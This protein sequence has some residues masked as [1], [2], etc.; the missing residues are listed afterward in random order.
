MTLRKEAPRKKARW[1]ALGIAVTA[2]LLLLASVA[3][4]GA[5][6]N[7]SF[8]GADGNL[9]RDLGTPTTSTD[10]NSFSPTWGGTAPYQNA[11]TTANGWAFKGLTDA[12]ASTTDTGFAGGTKQDDNCATVKGGKAPNK[13]DLKRVYLATKTVTVSSASHVFLALA[14]ERIPQNTVNASAHVGFEFNQGSTPC[15]T[16]HD[17]L[18]Q[19][20]A[21]DLLIVYDFEG[22]SSGS[23]TL[24]LRKWVT[25]GAC[26]ISSDSAPCWGPAATLTT[27][28]G[29]TAEAKVDA[30]A[31]AFPV[32]D[33]VA[34]SQDSLGQ[35]EFG[36]AIV[37]LSN[38]G[39]FGTA[40][41]TS[42]GQA[43]A[44][45]RSSGNSGQAAMEDLVGPATFTLS[46]CATVIIH[47]VTDPSSDTTTSFSFTKTFNT[48]PSSSNSFSLVG[49]GTK[50]YSGTVFATTGA[51][52][53]E[54]DPSGSNYTLS[55]ITCT[56]GSTATNIDRNA[57]T[58]ANGNGT[59]ARTVKFDIA[60]GQ[61]LECTFTNTKNLASPTVN[62]APSVIPEDK[63][64]VS[65]AFDATASTQ[66]LIHFEL[67][68]TST[69]D[70]TN[71]GTLLYSESQ[72][73]TA[74]G[75]YSTLNL[76]S[77]GTPAGYTISTSGEKDYWK[78]YYDGDSRNNPYN[79]GCSE[80]V[81]PT[82]SGFTAP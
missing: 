32:T 2:A 3:F 47:K 50:S 48:D 12:Q 33:T 37:D 7:S 14:W 45:S 27:V 59:A 54:S 36:E 11:S 39:V 71:G 60:S 26:E 79:A 24:T 5:A 61:T 80:Y 19:R 62:T 49:G 6:T 70:T 34:P 75:D 74:S 4:A 46:N 69:C 38:A 41:C 13:D 67:W 78:V 18:V 72:T 1:S 23:A 51:T 65:S 29:D 35:S 22:S 81:Q 42:F 64:T 57:S 77:N 8:E 82:L 31:G 21:G 25:S 20:T 17:G 58:T 9:T 55:S 44:V 52:V 28:G 56:A 10:W 40:S 68:S 30:A 63:A 15:G 73:V 66:G 16:G 76:G 53:T 43:E